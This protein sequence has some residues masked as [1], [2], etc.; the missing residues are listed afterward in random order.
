MNFEVEVLAAGIVIEKGDSRF[1]VRFSDFY[2]NPAQIKEGAFIRFPKEFERFQRLYALPLNKRGGK[3]E[4]GKISLGPTYIDD[5]SLK[6]EE[7]K[8]SSGS[9][10]HIISMVNLILFYTSS[11]IA[12]GCKE[13]DSQRKKCAVR[14]EARMYRGWKSPQGSASAHPAASHGLIEVTI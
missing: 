8:K 11:P 4:T 5:S 14:H 3:G 7:P 12:Y 2:I 13:K 10:V 1:K 9:T 6:K